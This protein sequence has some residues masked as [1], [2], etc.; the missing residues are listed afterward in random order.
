MINTTENQ[1][2]NMKPLKVLSLVLLALLLLVP[3]A[4]AE[5]YT[6][7]DED[8]EFGGSVSGGSIVPPSQYLLQSGSIEVTRDTNVGVFYSYTY[9]GSYY[10]EPGVLTWTVSSAFPGVYLDGVRLDE[11]TYEEPFEAFVQTGDKYGRIL[12]GL[13]QT[14]GTGTYEEWSAYLSFI[15]GYLISLSKSC[16]N[17]YVLCNGVQSSTSAC[18]IYVVP[19]P[20]PSEGVTQ[21]VTVTYTEESENYQIYVDTSDE[22][23]DVWVHGYVFG[24]FPV[25]TFSSNSFPPSTHFEWLDLPFRFLFWNV[26]WEV[27]VECGGESKVLKWNQDSLPIDVTPPDPDPPREPDLPDEPDP[28]DP[29]KPPEEP[30]NPPGYNPPGS[31][32]GGGSF[33][34]QSF[35]ELFTIP[36]SL[37]DLLNFDIKQIRSDLL[38]DIP[39]Y[40]D[41]AEGFFTALDT[42]RSFIF[43][44]VIFVIVSMLTPVTLVLDWFATFVEWFYNLC[45]SFMSFVYI[46]THI[47]E[48]LVLFIP[49]EI[50]NLALFLF[51]LDIVVGVISILV[52][53]IQYSYRLVRG[54]I[55]TRIPTR[56]DSTVR[57]ELD[58]YHSEYWGEPHYVDF[59]YD[60]HED[61]TDDGLHYSWRYK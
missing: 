2:K 35:R 1:P 12:L 49:N 19:Y 34:G 39:I 50:L 51:A 10:G 56:K 36:D 28:P 33:D 40:N 58:V 43:G 41:I 46:P 4:S 21:H 16:P 48:Y 3:A 59:D 6:L 22:S 11:Y 5:T 29:T 37:H 47:L 7:I 25:Y 14:G 53:D 57:T 26:D 18:N 24:W 31:G 54:M 17:S 20:E 55:A 30:P 13:F 38:A 42:V 44:S 60:E 8:L 27:K 45:F 32:G 15:E 52:P 23:V 9:E 61:T